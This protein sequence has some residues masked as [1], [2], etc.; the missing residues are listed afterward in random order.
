VP[1]TLSPEHL[2]A[3]HA[4]KAKAAA[5]KERTRKRSAKARVKAYRAWLKA[6]REYYETPRALRK[7]R[8]PVMPDLPSS[9]DFEDADGGAA[10][11]EPALAA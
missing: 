3:L 11:I 8:P 2:K 9:Q 5:D 4:G 7:G 1:R 6:D 10:T